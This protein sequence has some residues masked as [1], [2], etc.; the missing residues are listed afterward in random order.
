MATNLLGSAFVAIVPKPE[1]WDRLGD[2]IAS[3]IRAAVREVLDL[4]AQLDKA[5]RSAQ[6]T[7]T[8]AKEIGDA[9]GQALGEVKALGKGFDGATTAATRTVTATADIETGVKGATVSVDGLDVGLKGATASTAGLNAGLKDAAASAFEASGATDGIGRAAAGAAGS[10]GAVSGAL[11]GASAAASEAARNVE[12][13][14]AAASSAADHAGGLSSSLEEAGASVGEA[15]TEAEAGWAESFASVEEAGAGA[16]SLLTGAAAAFG[17]GLE[18]AISDAGRDAAEETGDAADEVQSRWK[19]AFTGIRDNAGSLFVAAGVA[20]AAAFTVGLQG[21]IQAQARD[22]LLSASLGISDEE[23][24][25]LGG[26]AGDLYAHAYGDSLGEVTA[27]VGTVRHSIQGMAQAS[28]EDLSSVSARALSISTAFGEDVVPTI[29][30]ASQLIRSGLAPDMDAALDLIATGFQKG[31]NYGGDFLDLLIERSPNLKQF[32]FDGASAIGFL[33]Q[34]MNA[35]ADSAGTVAGALDELIGNAGDSAEVFSELGFNGEKMARDLTGGGPK[36]AKALDALLEKL[37]SIQDPAKRATAF[38]SL[39]G[40]EASVFQSAILSLDPSN[41]VNALGQVEGAAARLDEK[42]GTG[43]KTALTTIRRTFESGFASL[44][45]IALPPIERLV[46]GIA[47]KIGPAFAVAEVGV[48]AFF[49]ALSGEGVTSAGFVGGMER[50]GVVVRSL[51]ETASRAWQLVLPGLRDLGSFVTQSVWPALQ[52]LWAVAKGLWP[53]VQRIGQIVGTILLVAFRALAAV[54]A[55]VIGPA[56][57]EMTGFWRSN[58]TTITALAVAIGAGVVAW[59]AYRGAVAAVTTAQWIWQTRTL[60]M[61]VIMRNVRTAM[62]AMRTATLL[63]NSAFLANPIGIIIVALVALAAGFAYAYTHS[64]T[65][66][67]IVQGALAWVSGAAQ[68]AG[69]WFVA[70]GSD[71]GGVLTAVSSGAQAFGGFFV[72]IFRGI[73]DYVS[74]IVRGGLAIWRGVID[75]GLGGI[76]AAAQLWWIYF[77]TPFRVGFE[78]IRGLFSFFSALFRG[79][80]DGAWNAISGTTTRVL[81]IV[82]GAID[83][84]L[85]AIKTAFQTTKD[86]IGVIWDGLKTVASAP[87]KFVVE[88]VYNNGIRRAWNSIVAKIPG[89]P[90]MPAL[91]VPGLAAGGPIAGGVRG[92]DSVLRWLMPGEHVLTTAEVN[93]AGGHGRIF[94]LRRALGGGTQASGVG[95]ALG[96]VGDALGAAWNATGG[97]AVD[98]LEDLAR[99]GLAKGF[100][101][102]VSPIR[103]AM[104]STLG[105]GDNWRGIIN[106]LIQ[107]PFDKLIEWV[108]GKEAEMVPDAGPV[109]AGVARWSGVSSAVLNETGQSLSWLPLLLKR[110]NQE[111]GGNPRA[112]NLWDSN[113]KAGIPSKGLMQVIDPTFRAYAGPH[114]GAGIWDPHANIYAA[115]KYSL[116]RYGSLGKAWNRAG[117]YDQGGPLHPGWTMAYNGTGHDEWVSVNKPSGGVLVAAGAIQQN[118]DARGASDPNA[119]EAAVERGN[120]RM[121]RELTTLLQ[122]GEGAN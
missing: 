87:V 4:N 96:G 98:K 112:I 29:T 59:Y 99:A 57:R 82:R 19:R 20:A 46:T 69:R 72:G 109:G 28:A 60:I 50:A 118:I 81:G 65:F 76:L 107:T 2:Q 105:R 101:L 9:A 43:A 75:I 62:A 6:R 7:A 52:N 89:V 38:V 32:G 56:L 8:S 110:M 106:R 114:I 73:F 88:T 21:S 61:E 53:D 14:G 47:G 10:V 40:E 66:R 16:F 70:F 24:T 115:T 67:N 111:S 64:E 97:R 84:G 17:L 113:A 108:R 54:L 94:A 55:N 30:A 119:I 42:M 18:D 34:G 92:Q 33:V 122:Q 74:S 83:S 104:N 26:V 27:A 85:G 31:A 79:D 15:A 93:A 44:A 102:A 35:G 1:R 23:A 36:A 116:S 49:S 90:E 25:R 13:I 37:R 51:G 45:S 63:L 86:G 39:F 117:G 121:L 95:M 11:T 22:I 78:V 58:Q 12:G 120:E 100:E 103:G 41:A 91:S 80:W 77:T 3:K 5:G 48:R 68:A 71:V